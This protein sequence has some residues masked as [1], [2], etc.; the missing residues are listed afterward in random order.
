MSPKPI[1]S[2]PDAPRLAFAWE[3]AWRN[4][5]GQHALSYSE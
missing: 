3:Y 5:T 4:V 2:T 1:P